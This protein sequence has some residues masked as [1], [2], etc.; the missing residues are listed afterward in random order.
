MVQKKFLKTELEE[1]APLVLG[2]SALQ[3]MCSLAIALAFRD[4]GDFSPT[5]SVTPSDSQK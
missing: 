2:G 5:F 4:S 3:R 1:M